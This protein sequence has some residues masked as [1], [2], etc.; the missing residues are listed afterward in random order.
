VS[1]RFKTSAS[2]IVLML[3]FV[4]QEIRLRYRIQTAEE[5]VGAYGSCGEEQTCLEA[6]D[7]EN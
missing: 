6:F 5:I 7:R 2:E 1:K 3:D 4:Q